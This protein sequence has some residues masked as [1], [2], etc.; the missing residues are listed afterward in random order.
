MKG[1]VTYF[2]KQRGYGF[3]RG[4]D[5][6]DYFVHLSELPRNTYLEQEDNVKFTP[7]ES[8]KGPQAREVVIL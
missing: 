7:A 3:I 6:K 2:N 8:Q 5:E 4:E 1:K